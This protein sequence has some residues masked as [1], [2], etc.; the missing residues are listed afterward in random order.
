[1]GRKFEVCS[2]FPNAKLP[3]RATKQSAGYDFYC[4]ETTVVPSVWKQV[5]E[6]LK[7]FNILNIEATM[8]RFSDLKEDLCKPTLVPT[9][10]KAQM[11][12]DEVLVLANRSSNPLKTK[13][14]V[15]NGVG[16]VDADFYNNETDEGHIR[17]QFIN[18]GMSDRTIVEG[19]KVGQGIFQKF[20]LTDDDISLELRKGGHGSTDENAWNS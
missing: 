1:M 15:S 14:I 11:E 4:A 8:K 7:D 9:G 2:Y 13:L 17:F 20:L 18:L 3:V 5:L 12:P 10:I 6:V 16:I 19:E